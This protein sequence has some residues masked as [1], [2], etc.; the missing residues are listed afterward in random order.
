MTDN[1]MDAMQWMQSAGNANIGR[2]CY[3]YDIIIFSQTSILYFR[4]KAISIILFSNT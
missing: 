3:L 2:T 4:K 1:D